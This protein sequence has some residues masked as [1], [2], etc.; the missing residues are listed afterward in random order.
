MRKVARLL[1]EGW[2]PARVLVV[3]FTRTAAADLRGQLEDL[4]EPGAELVAASTLH[5]LC[6]RIL[7]KQGVLEKTKRNPR[8]LYDFEVGTML[9][10][11]GS[12][13]GGKRERERR[14]KAYEAAWARLQSEAAGTAKTAEDRLFDDRVNQWLRFHDAMLVGELVPIAFQYLSQNP[15]SAE[16]AAYEHVLVDEYQD[17]NRADQGVI[18]ALSAHATL[19]AVGDDNQSIYSFRYANP[20]GILEFPANHGGT[21]EETLTECRRCP[22]DVV[23]VANCLIDPNSSRPDR[24]LVTPNGTP[25]G[26]VALLRWINPE[27][28]TGGICKII[29]GLLRSH[30]PSSAGDILVLVPRKQLGSWL[31]AELKTNFVPAEALF[32]DDLLA[33]DEAR[34]RI[35][36][37]Q[38]LVDPADKTAL[39]YWL[40]RNSVTTL[41]GGYAKLRAE[42]ER[43]NEE[44]AKILADIAAGRRRV[45]NTSALVESYQDLQAELQRLQPLDGSRFIDAWIPPD[46]DEVKPLRE[47]VISSVNLESPREQLLQ[48]LRTLLT[49][50][51][52][53]STAPYVRIMT[54]H[55]AKGLSSHTVIVL[56]LVEGLIPTTAQGV[57][58][59]EQRRLLYV[60]VTRA[61]SQLILSTW[62]QASQ[63][64]AMHLG[65]A[66]GGWVRRGTLRVRPSQF[67]RDLGRPPLVPIP[68]EELVRRL[69]N[70]A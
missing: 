45:A 8:T 61:R 67:L 44:P 52:V 57:S 14:L 31:R 26:T 19:T 15:D 48:D 28:E 12:E 46:V 39:R 43:T 69:E 30:S 42:C 17:L 33:T 50:P 10:D 9:A 23:R 22:S 41:A 16:N 34:E 5:S 11:L 21:Q 38:L 55:K 25:S 53:P 27:E 60:A 13:F 62:S 3:T 24:Q 1:E 35:A 6:F 70:N 58:L 65:A 40:G 29:A 64:A 7:L 2:N 49:Q 51:E 36:L 63:D 20:E 4:G 68:G 66:A 54:L 18:E 37:L 47:M 56:G 59:D 32:T